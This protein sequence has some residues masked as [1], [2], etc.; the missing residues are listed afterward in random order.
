MVCDSSRDFVAFSIPSFHYMDVL[1]AELEVK[2][3][4]KIRKG[5]KRNEI[6]QRGGRKELTE[7]EWALRGRGRGS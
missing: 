7:G 4:D 3:G 5:G 1:L 2:L 6:R